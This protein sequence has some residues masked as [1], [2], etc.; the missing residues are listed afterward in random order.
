MVVICILGG[1]PAGGKFTSSSPGGREAPDH[2]R[3]VVIVGDVSNERWTEVK[4][5]FRREDRQRRVRRR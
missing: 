3:G 5:G 4:S 1:L 2:L